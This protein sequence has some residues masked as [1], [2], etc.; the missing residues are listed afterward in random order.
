MTGD[1]QRTANTIAQ[2]LGIRNF[3]AQVLQ[4]TR[5]EQIKKLQK[6]GKIVAMIGDGVND[7]PALT[8]SDIGIAMGFRYWCCSLIRTYNTY[9]RRF[10]LRSFCI[11]N[12]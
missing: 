8:Q 2:K 9:E 1:N 6:Q 3:L 7:A 5:V 4:E 11:K 12:R 10:A